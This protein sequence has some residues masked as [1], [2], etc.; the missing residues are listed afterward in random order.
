MNDDPTSLTSGRCLCGDIRFEFR[1]AAIGVEHCHCESCR[2]HTSAPFATFVVVDKSAFRYTRGSPVPF[3]SSPGVE[4][5]HCGR[6]GAPI[7]YENASE[8]ALYAGTL[9]E[10]SSV[11]PSRH[12][13]VAEKLPWIEIADD[14][15][16]FEFSAKNASPMKS[17][18]KR[19]TT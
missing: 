10:P 3:A 9:D 6:C 16:Q 1:G 2:R 13:F 19:P 18:T 4:R 7:A 8:F 5:T 12:I 11:R 14:L 17:P 15:P